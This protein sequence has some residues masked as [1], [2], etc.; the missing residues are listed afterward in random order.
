MIEAK[1]PKVAI[2]ILNWN[3]ANDTIECLESVLKSK[4]DSFTIFLIDNNSGDNSVVKI[5]QWLSGEQKA[6]IKTKFPELV[7][8]AVQK[9]VS[10][11][12]IENDIQDFLSAQKLYDNLHNLP[13]AKVVFILNSENL[14]FAKGNNL[15]IKYII[16]TDRKYDYIYMLN[17]DTV[18][19]PETVSELITKMESENIDVA[20][21]IIYYYNE[22][23]KISFAGG[24]LLPWAKAK[25]FYTLPDSEYRDSAFAHGCAL[26]VKKQVF[27]KHGA[28]T[29]RFFHGEEDFEFSWRLQKTEI[30][31]TCIKTSRIYHKEGVTIGNHFDRKRRLSLSVINRLVDMKAFLTPLRWNLWK[32]F[33]LPYYFYLFTLKHG[34]GVT[35]SFKLLIKVNKLAKSL[36]SVPKSTFDH[37]YNNL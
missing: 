15:I 9:P 18:I 37:I 11:Q 7:F 35:K 32:M 23:E 19:E 2:I 3:N 36:D 31:M 33:V 10:H 17:N 14:G 16:S 24:K 29:E 25:Y 6:K 28:L 22:R 12:I 27:Q 5:E 30:K 34:N 21:S 4:Y 8:P 20:N 26:M 1:I 13:Q